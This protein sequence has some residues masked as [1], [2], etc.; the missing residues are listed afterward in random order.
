M[1]NVLVISNC[2]L[3][4]ALVMIPALRSLKALPARITLASE[5]A[6]HGIVAAEDILGDRNL[7]DCFVKM[8]TSGSFFARFLDRLRFFAR[9]R[10]KKWDLGVVLMPPCPP[11]T[12]RLVKRLRTYLRLCGCR[13]IIAPQ[14]IYAD[15]HVADMMLD[16][17]SQNG[18]APIAD[19][20][21]P[22]LEKPAPSPLPLGK[23]YIA[24]A[25]GA[26]MPVNC[27]KLENYAAVLNLLTAKYNFTPVYFSGENERKI[28]EQLNETVPGHTVIGKP[29]PEVES[30]M[31]QCRAYL[32]NDTGLVHLA[33]ALGLP[34]LCI[35]SNRN[36]HGIWEPYTTHKLIFYP[37]DCGCTGCLRQDC[38]KMCI[39]KTTP[40]KV[41]A[42]IESSPL[43]P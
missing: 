35:Y 3:G 30:A 12:M 31:R 8:S 20:S 7:V 2:R 23:K 11:L 16:M 10:R 38:D 24:V 29:L 22:P 43:M 13:Q 21:L 36:P 9:M 28:C 27:W 34:C 1:Q 40:E 33:A 14:D 19:A 32:G 41:L 15:K 25:P 18:I 4:D 37:E 26:N 6:A 39:N 42:A 5:A 17:L